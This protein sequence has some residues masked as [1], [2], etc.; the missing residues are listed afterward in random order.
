MH[1]VY[2]SAW[3]PPLFFLRKQLSVCVRA[4]GEAKGEGLVLL[5]CFYVNLRWTEEEKKKENDKTWSTYCRD[6]CVQFLS[7]YTRKMVTGDGVRRQHTDVFLGFFGPHF[8][9]VHLCY[10]AVHLGI[11]VW[12]QLN[13]RIC[14]HFSTVLHPIKLSQISNFQEY[15]HLLV[16]CSGYVPSV[17]QC[18]LKAFIFFF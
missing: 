5:S 15:A 2:T 7:S 13:F 9:S 14:E 8:S 4:S 11:S 12:I 1:L 17:C 3:T 6:R 10:D 18:S 16:H